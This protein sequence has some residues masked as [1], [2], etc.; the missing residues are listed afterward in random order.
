MRFHHRISSIFIILEVCSSFL[1]PLSS[2][3]FPSSFFFFFPFSSFSSFP[4]P[5]W[6]KGLLKWAKWTWG[7]LVSIPEASPAQ[8]AELQWWGWVLKRSNWK[9]SRNCLANTCSKFDI[10]KTFQCQL[11]KLFPATSF[12]TTQKASPHLSVWHGSCCGT[13]ENNKTCS[14]KVCEFTTEEGIKQMPGI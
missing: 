6:A 11:M 10:L 1:F 8:T 13:A 9:P 7:S 5:V 14:H 3:F 2:F 12:S 4:F